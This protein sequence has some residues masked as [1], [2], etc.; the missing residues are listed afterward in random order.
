MTQNKRYQTTPYLY[1]RILMQD[2]SNIGL[3][4]PSVFSFWELDI[5]DIRQKVRELEKKNGVKIS[6][7]IYLLYCFIQTINQQKHTQGI[8]SWWNKK[9]VYNDI[10]LCIPIELSN[11]TL[12]PKIIRRANYKSIFELR[13]EILNTKKN[14]KVKLA[15]W[16]KCFLYF[17][18]F[19]KKIG[20]SI[21]LSTPLFRKH[22]FGTAY[23]SSLYLRS[24]VSIS[25]QPI[26]LHPIGML[27]GSIEKR[28]VIEN[29]KISIREIMP[30]TNSMDHRINDGVCVHHFVNSLHK[31]I[32][33]LILHL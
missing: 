22:I 7:T 4:T 14:K 3:K 21:V 32:K 8:K 1:E 15:Y 2:I 23:F 28:E 20:Y 6:L 27:L 19:L 5:T 12:D 24:S 13:K 11:K 10:D 33:E 30:I 17:P 18:G 9:Y 29:G 31:N 25:Y 26:P 16:Q